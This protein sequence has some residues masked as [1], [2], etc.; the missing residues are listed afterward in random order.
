[1]RA[2]GRPSVWS[3]ASSLLLLLLSIST[4]H[5]CEVI[6]TRERRERV[7][8]EG[9]LRVVIGVFLRVSVVGPCCWSVCVCCVPG[10]FWS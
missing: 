7:G 8:K 1:M 3:G 4:L 6:G 5:V 10:V 9:D 2:A